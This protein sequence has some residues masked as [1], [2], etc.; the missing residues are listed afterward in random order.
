MENHPH[1]SPPSAAFKLYFGPKTQ[2]AFPGW[3]KEDSHGQPAA[4]R[5]LLMAAGAR[6]E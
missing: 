2:R 5:G 4:G 6:H 1:Q 3:L